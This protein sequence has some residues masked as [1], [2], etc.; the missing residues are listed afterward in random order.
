LCGG[1][2]RSQEVTFYGENDVWQ[3][4]FD[5]A[6]STHDHTIASL[7]SQELVRLLSLSQTLKEDGEVVLIAE[8]L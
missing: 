8:L 7:L 1:P 5:L 4:L 2:L 3:N 6:L